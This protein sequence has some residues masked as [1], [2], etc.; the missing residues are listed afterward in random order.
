MSFKRHDHYGYVSACFE[1]KCKYCKHS[2]G[3]VIN[4][5]W[6]TNSFF[7]KEMKSVITDKILIQDSF[8]SN[9]CVCDVKQR[10]TN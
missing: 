2:F 8:S 5:Y 10:Q 1:I 9:K 4:K 7:S 3:V 6:N